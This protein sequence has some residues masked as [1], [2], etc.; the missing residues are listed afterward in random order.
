[1]GKRTQSALCVLISRRLGALRRP[2]AAGPLARELARQVEFWAPL[3]R[4]LFTAA[5]GDL[6]P[7]NVA[8][9]HDPLTLL[10]LVDAS[11]LEFEDLVILPTIEGGVL[12]TIEARR[13]WGVG[14]EMRVATGVDPDRARIQILERLLQA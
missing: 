9:L 3:Q 1:M 10:S 13:D 14:A 2:H 7:D 4:K 11:S 12:R 5:G 8:F 6:A